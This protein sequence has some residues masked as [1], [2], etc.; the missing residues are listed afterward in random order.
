MGFR[1]ELQYSRSV[2]RVTMQIVALDLGGRRVSLDVEP[3]IGYAALRLEIAVEMGLDVDV[4]MDLLMGDHILPLSSRLAL[5]EL[6]IVDGVSLTVVKRPSPRLL[7]AALDGTAKLWDT[8]TGECLRTFA[9]HSHHGISKAIFSFDGTLVLT[10]TY[11]AVKTWNASTGECVL[12]LCDDGYG[13]PVGL[14]FSRLTIEKCLRTDMQVPP[15]GVP[16]QGR[17]FL[18]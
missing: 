18:R 15:F 13:R 10:M 16:R 7:T 8:M 14:A 5:T 11:N 12:T 4:G 9:G 3:G 2:V 17:V 6:G 1:A